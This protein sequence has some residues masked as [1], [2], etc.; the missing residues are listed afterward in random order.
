MRVLGFDRPH[1][2]WA[3]LFLLLLPGGVGAQLRTVVSNEIAVS[4]SEATLHLDLRDDGEL[5]IAFRGGEVLVDGETVGEYAR[6]DLLDRAWRALL[7][8]VLALDD[9]PLAQALFDWE[10]PEGLT[11]SEREVANLLDE[12]M[13]SALALPQPAQDAPSP[14]VSITVPG[15][16]TLLGALLRRSDALKGL[17]EAL[18]GVNLSTTTIHVDED[19]E[20]DED[21]VVEGTLILVDAD[22]DVRGTIQG[23]VVVA[24]G[25]VRLLDGGRI[26]GNLRVADGNVERE[27]GSVEGSV[28]VIG[29]EEETTVRAQDMESLR[30]DLERQIR[31]EVARESPP[32]PSLLMAPLRNLGQAIAGL[33]E[34][35]AT[36]LVLAILGV[37][38]VH[39]GR[40]RLEVVALTARRAPARSALVGLA[41]G[42]LLIPVWILGMVALA[43][44]IIGIPV[45]LAWIP[46][47]P[48]AAGLAALLGYLAVA[49]NVGEWVADQEYRGLE[50]IRGSNAFYAVVAGLGAFMVPCVAANVARF[51]GLGFFHGLLAFVGSAIAFMAAAI[52]LGA[53]LLTRGGR[54]RPYETYYEFEDEYWT[55]GESAETSEPQA[56]QEPEG[57]GVPPES[58]EEP[59]KDEDHHG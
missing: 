48:I 31:R 38:A 57:E 20:V 56:P 5:A 35:L 42:F 47:F 43:V 34:N 16:G 21:E 1:L 36:F 13:E 27:G 6:G 49:R 55:D 7:G 12:A 29:A 2:G 52:G 44:S 14:E 3:V 17:A 46:L 45:L 32:A 37:L 40:E 19:V 15:E 53:V 33:L 11:G 9:G 24:G 8:N 18:E 51:L 25:T 30:R 58:E 39:F 26:T 59:E 22:L 41:G 23:D 4:G 28:S 10:P 54:I 50:W